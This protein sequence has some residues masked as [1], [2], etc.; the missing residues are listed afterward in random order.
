M[1]KASH[2]LIKCLLEF[3]LI[4]FTLSPHLSLLPSPLSLPSIIITSLSP[5]HS[6]SL[7]QPTSPLSL[8][9]FS[10]I[11]P[12][13]FDTARAQADFFPQMILKTSIFKSLLSSAFHTMQNHSLVPRPPSE[14]SRKGLATRMAMRCPRGLYTRANQIAEIIYVTFNR[15]CANSSVYSDHHGVQLTRQSKFPEAE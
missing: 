2:S 3:T 11:P 13:L 6:T 4:D 12:Y 7:P 5:F 1:L 8:P 9:F 15:G 14:K 10:L